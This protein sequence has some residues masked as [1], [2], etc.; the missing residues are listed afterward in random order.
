M[1]SDVPHPIRRWAKAVIG[2]VDH[3]EDLKTTSAWGRHVGIS[4]T[5]LREH[6]RLADLTTKDSLDLARLL[7]AVLHCERTPWPI[8]YVLDVSD[9]RTLRRLLERGN[10]VA[11][12]LPE[13]A[14]EFLRGQR[15]ITNQV[16]VEMLIE[17]L[18]QWRQHNLS[19]G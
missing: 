3:N 8:N 10:C 9:S 18:A 19:D 7:R 17:E 5:Q 14:E 4:V 12:E 11:R 6:C 16:A 2:I 15:I 1:T 13:T